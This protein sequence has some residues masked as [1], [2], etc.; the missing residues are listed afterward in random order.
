[1]NRIVL[2]FQEQVYNVASVQLI[3]FGL[4]NYGQPQEVVQLISNNLRGVEAIYQRNYPLGTAEL[5]VDLAGD[6]ESLAA[7]LTTRAIG[8]YRFEIEDSTHN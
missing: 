3:I 2:I 8:N 4:R 1:M 6:T 7:D 5:E